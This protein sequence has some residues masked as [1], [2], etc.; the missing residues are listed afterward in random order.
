MNKKKLSVVMLVNKFNGKTNRDEKTT[1]EEN[2]V[3]LGLGNV[4]IQQLSIENVKFI[5]FHWNETHSIYFSRFL[6][7]FLSMQ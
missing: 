7:Q 2:R 3:F 1:F 4:Y 5:I 6:N